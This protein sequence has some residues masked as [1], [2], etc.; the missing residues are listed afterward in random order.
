MKKKTCYEQQL[1][2]I[3]STHWVLLFFDVF[4]SLSLVSGFSFQLSLQFVPV[5][6]AAVLTLNGPTWSTKIHFAR[7]VRSKSSIASMH[8]P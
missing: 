5:D 7:Q 6:E 3:V 8:K 4:C 2:E 1:V